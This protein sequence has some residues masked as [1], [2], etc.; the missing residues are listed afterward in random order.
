[1]TPFL[2]KLPYSE[3]LVKKIMRFFYFFHNFVENTCLTVNLSHIAC[4][5]A[6]CGSEPILPPIKNSRREAAPQFLIFHFYFLISLRRG[7]RHQQLTAV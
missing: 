3:T 6:A 7:L 4:A 5:A 2:R 1:M